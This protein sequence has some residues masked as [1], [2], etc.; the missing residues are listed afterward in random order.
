MCSQWLGSGTAHNHLEQIGLLVFDVI[1]TFAAFLL[2]A[3]GTDDWA[4]VTDGTNSFICL[5][6]LSI[7][8]VVIFYFMHMY[9]SMWRYASI[10]EVARILVA[11]LLGSLVGDVVFSV[12]FNGGLNIR[13]YLMAWAILLILCAGVR[14]A[15]RAFWGSQNRHFARKSEEA[16]P[17]TLVVGAGETGSLTIKRMLKGDEDLL[18]DP[19]AVADDDPAKYGLYV[20]GTKV[21]GATEDIPEI[22]TKLNVAQIVFAI[23]SAS[24]SQRQ[25]IYDICMETGLKVYTL[26]N[27]RDVPVEEIGHMALRDVE[28]TDLLSRDEIELDIGRMSYVSGKVVLVTGGGGSI[29]SE[30]VRQLLPIRPKR[31]ILFDIYENTTYEFYHEI[32]QLAANQGTEVVVEI[33]SIT[34][35]GA[36]VSLFEKHKPHVVFHAAAH[37]HVPLMENNVSEAV[38]NNVF[39]TQ[40]LAHLADESKCTH[41][42]LISTDKAVNPTNVMGATKRM[43][44]MNIQYFAQESNTIFAAVRFG[45]VLGSHG[46]VVP[47]FKRQMREGGPIT[48]THKDI[49]RY[50]MTI[51]EASR[52]V[53]SA[54]SLAKGGEIFILK[55]GEPVR[56]FDLA[57]NLVKLSGLKLGRDVEIEITGLRPGEKLYE[58][59]QMDDEEPDQTENEDI[60]VSKGKPI[61]K[62][63]LTSRLFKLEEALS[64]G[65]EVVKKT[66]A[67]VVPSYHPQFD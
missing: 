30:L 65:D 25:R 31:V 6:V 15:A 1:A 34:N 62:E 33:G 12:A 43:C 44:E 52:L 29:G 60:V 32:V 18:G 42:I 11:T 2:S 50:F 9:T 63:D 56:I 39:G 4:L 41:F 48:L 24:K 10:T 35:M 40:N 61:S 37:K 23:P 55:M 66:L 49:T 27:V 47:L 51:P 57:V 46:S 8:N 54:G 67:E 58:E 53:L 28:I 36:L 45:N 26:P 3:W 38:E 64:L 13:M 16:L 19:V 14:L 22:A 59:L 5:T 17:R 20:H 7:I 21:L